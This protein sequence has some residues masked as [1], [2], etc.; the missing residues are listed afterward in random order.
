MVRPEF[1][2]RA[3]QIPT[4]RGSYLFSMIDDILQVR[5]SSASAAFR[6]CRGLSCVC[7]LLLMLLLLTG[8]RSGS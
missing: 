1:E 6:S 4:Q 2:P 7:R 8:A 3:C 5:G